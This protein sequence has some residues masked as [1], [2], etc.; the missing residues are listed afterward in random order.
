MNAIAPPQP[1]P[2]P[3]KRLMAMAIA[4]FHFK[5]DRPSSF[6]TPYRYATSTNTSKV[7][8]SKFWSLSRRAILWLSEGRS[9]S[10]RLG[11]TNI[12]LFD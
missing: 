10:L 4:D 7:R 1:T 12:L 11:N 5:C 3:R 2:P 8:S 6:A 9:R